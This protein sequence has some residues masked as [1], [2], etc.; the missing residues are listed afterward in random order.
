VYTNG[1]GAEFKTGRQN[2][3]LR[4]QT[5]S[6]ALRATAENIPVSADLTVEEDRKAR[7][8]KEIVVAATPLFAELGFA[9]CDMERVAAELPIAKGTLYLYF[10]SK[11]ELFF[12]CVDQGMQD[13]QAALDRAIRPEDD[14]FRR[15]ARSIWVFL[16]FFDESPQHIELLIQERAIFRDRPRPTFF[17]YRD[18]R[19]DRWRDF[20]Q[21]LIDAGRLRSDLAIDDLLDSIGNMLYGTMFTNY[22]AGRSVPLCQQYQAVIE[23]LFRGMLSDAERHRLGNLSPAD[24]CDQQPAS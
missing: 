9:D 10:R 2:R 21:A 5:H 19:R 18:A 7:R 23:L 20:Y 13:L 8:R 4:R 12:A 1:P 14:P 15:I 6:P 3:A 24:L 22:F 11:Q 17:I 16:Q